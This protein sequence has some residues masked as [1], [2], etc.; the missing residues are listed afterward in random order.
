[1]KEK[2]ESYKY[3]TKNKSKDAF[4]DSKKDTHMDSVR[5][6]FK[7]QRLSLDCNSKSR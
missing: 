4:E 2:K 7:L 1:M 3:L 5:S 6:V